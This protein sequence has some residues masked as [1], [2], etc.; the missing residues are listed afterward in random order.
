MNQGRSAMWWSYPFAVVLGMGFSYLGATMPDIRARLAIAEAEAGVLPLAMSLG[1][2]AGNLGLGLL[3]GAMTV[4]RWAIVTM[5]VFSM[6]HLAVARGSGLAI[7]CVGVCGVSLAFGAGLVLCS[8]SIQ[9]AS[10]RRSARAMNVVHG[11]LAAGITVEPI[12]AGHML[13]RG[14]SFRVPAAV[15]AAIAAGVLLLVACTAPPRAERLRGITRQSVA[16]LLGRHRGV[17]LGLAFLLACS[18]G[19]EAVAN[20]WFPEFLVGAFPGRIGVAGA[21]MAL[22]AFWAAVTLGRWVTAALAGR[23]RPFGIAIGL[24]LL[25]LAGLIV[26]PLCPHPTAA[27]IA[28]VAVG[29]GLSGLGPI[30][31]SGVDRL[32]A[33]HAPAALALVMAAGPLGGAIFAPLVGP[34]AEHYGFRVAICIALVP[35]ALLMT[36]FIALRARHGSPR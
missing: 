22:S 31:L 20:V 23:V 21:G 29:L 2:V 19:V 10:A 28:I 13:G 5:A 8:A 32:P 14:L 12:V 27:V 25:V 7:V 6:G 3:A 30:I 35:A 15:L 17:F 36:G 9:Q 11:F 24:S 4:K 16:G 26:L 18:V 33:E 1:L 34:V